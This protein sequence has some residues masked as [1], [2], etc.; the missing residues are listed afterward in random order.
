[1]DFNPLFLSDAKSLFLGQ[2]EDNMAAYFYS[3]PNPAIKN[4]TVNGEKYYR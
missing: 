2:E 3:T 1:M 4:D